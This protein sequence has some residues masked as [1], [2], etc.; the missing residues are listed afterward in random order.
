M[1]HSTPSPLPSHSSQAGRLP[2][3]TGLSCGV[4][5]FIIFGW[6]SFR[7]AAFLYDDA[8]QVAHTHQVIVSLGNISS[9]M[10]DAETGQRGFLLTNSA[11]Y[12]APFNAAHADIDQ[13]SPPSSLNC[14]KPST[15]GEQRALW[16]RWPW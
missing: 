13:A 10:K 5:F 3:I 15:L 8:Q 2:V 4:L 7:N 11:T 16:L 6:I 12:L 1:P 14:R 9:M